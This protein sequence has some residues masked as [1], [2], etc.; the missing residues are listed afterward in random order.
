MITNALWYV[1]NQTLH[2]DLKVPFI[3]D[4]IQEKS[5]NHHNKLE[6]IVIPY[7]S[8]YWNTKKKKA[9]E[10]LASGPN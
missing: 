1:T 3:K 5:I 2:D 7:C 8:H 10:T 9:K 6:T 4:A